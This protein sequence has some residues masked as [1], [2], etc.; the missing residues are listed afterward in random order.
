MDEITGTPSQLIEAIKF[1]LPNDL[2]LMID[3]AP[4][5]GKTDI[6]KQ[7][8]SELEYDLILGHP[9]LADP[10]VY[11][12]L[13]FP[14]NGEYA[15]FLPFGELK[16]L[17]EAMRPTAYFC[18]DVGQAVYAVQS[19]LMQVTWGKQTNSHKI[20]EHIKFLMATNRRQDKAN[21][22]GILATLKSR[23]L[24]FHLV[25]S[26]EDWISWGITH[27][28]PAV[29][30]AFIKFRPELLHDFKPNYDMINSPCPRTV[31]ELGKAINAGC[32]KSIEPQIFAGCCGTGF[33]TE[34]LAFLDMFRALPSI[35][36]IFKNPNDVEIDH[37]PSV[38]YAIT[39]ALFSRV[40]EKNIGPAMSYIN[41]LPKE[42][43][44]FFIKSAV[45]KNKSI[46]NTA[47]ARDWFLANGSVLIG[48]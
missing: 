4:G 10:T 30:L 6:V 3:G 33:T 25:V 9:Q 26:H 15:S 22:A 8:V 48:N 42:F 18:D 43:Q 37:E 34:F 31:A 17:I 27:K 47:P 24:L 20:S 21:V 13:P 28:M 14:V 45:M 46:S 29:L 38:L 19:A 23:F 5:I 11:A 16:K 44:V 7:A 35:D 32:P 12:G 36:L 39:S 40:T 1:C 2:N 41:R